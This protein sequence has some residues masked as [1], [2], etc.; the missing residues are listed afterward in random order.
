MPKLITVRAAAF[1]RGA[2]DP[3]MTDMAAGPVTALDRCR[4]VEAGP[5]SGHSGGMER[6]RAAFGSGLARAGLTA[7]ATGVVSTSNKSLGV[8]SSAVHNASSVSRFTCPGCLVS[9]P[10]TDPDDNCPPDPSPSQPPTRA[11]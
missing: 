11:P 5:V 1:Q 6:P 2:G 10:D 7:G 9:S 4:A 8:H 3:A